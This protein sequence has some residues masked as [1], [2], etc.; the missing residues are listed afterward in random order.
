[1]AK[2]DLLL[3]GPWYDWD[4][5]PLNAEFNV[6]P[7]S[8]DTDLTT[9]DADFRARVRFA[10]LKGHANVGGDFM[11]HFPKLELIANYGVGYDAI[12][13]VAAASR[14]I[15]VT[16]TPDVLSADVA[17]LAVMMLLS[18]L[19]QSVGAEA[20]L[21]SGK[22]GT[23]GDYPLQRKMS[24]GR[25]GIVG[26]GRIG[27]AIADRM[28]AFEMPISYY[29]RAPKSDVPGDWI[30]YGSPQ[31]LAANVDF[32]VV[33]LSGGPDT[34]G[35]V[36]AA[37]IKALEPNGVLVNISRGSTIDEAALLDALE[38]RR[39]GGAALDVFLN[40]PHPDPRFIPLDNVLLLPHVASATEETR[41]AMGQ[42]AIA[43]LLA[44][45]DG[46]ALLTRVN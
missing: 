15:A 38:S 19:R 20:W 35:L 7:I 2:P 10:T 18:F 46:K 31:E 30:Y 32:L 29:S 36:D 14:G 13:V 8:S 6:T 21:R 43:N 12:D 40:E 37:T 23:D 11:D 4:L 1:M 5:E 44:A 28:A 22:W 27:R 33:A 25:A 24:G 3:I 34:A 26:L 41:R 42:L 16:N 9:L 45:R 39:I 17:D